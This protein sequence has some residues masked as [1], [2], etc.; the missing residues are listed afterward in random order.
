MKR[1][2]SRS[3]LQGRADFDRPSGTDQAKDQYPYTALTYMDVVS[4]EKSDETQENVCS[5]PILLRV[6]LDDPKIGFFDINVKELV[7]KG[8][9]SGLPAGAIS[10]PPLPFD[11]ALVCPKYVD[12]YRTFDKPVDAKADQHNDAVFV[13][14]ASVSDWTDPAQ[15]EQYRT[16]VDAEVRVF[17][18]LFDKGH[19]NIVKFRGCVVEDGLIVGVALEKCA[20]DLWARLQ[21]ATA[22]LDVDKCLAQV[23]G[24]IIHLHGLGYCHNDVKPDNIM[25]RADDTAV[26][27]DFD[28]CLPTDEPLD[29]GKGT[30]VV[31]SDPTST[32]SC[33]KNDWLG[34]GNGRGADARPNGGPM[35]VPPRLWPQQSWPRRRRERQ[36]QGQRRR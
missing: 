10:G 28:S 2:L 12:T 31:W 19:P 25:F 14:K 24:A 32:T 17:E 22:P 11:A 3:L 18:M 8:K 29:K 6:V 27:I 4:Y 7:A 1:V 30:T 34:L 23:A 33:G 13:K 21:E 15:C 20:K 35:G 36:W 5:A 16:W 26:L 9:A